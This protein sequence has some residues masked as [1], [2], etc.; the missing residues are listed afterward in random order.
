VQQL[1][2]IF[3]RSVISVFQIYFIL[4]IKILK[5]HRTENRIQHKFVPYANLSIQPIIQKKLG[6]KLNAQV[7]EFSNSI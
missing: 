5:I 6:N 3:A 1:V 2:L 7:D 4:L